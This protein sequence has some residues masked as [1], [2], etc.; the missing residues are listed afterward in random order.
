MNKSGETGSAARSLAPSKMPRKRL[1]SRKT[2]G[3]VGFFS[4]TAAMVMSVHEYPTFAVAGMQIPFFLI[5]AGFLW[6]LPVALC[7]AEMATV[8]S[9]EEEG[10]FSWVGN[11]LGE[12]FGFAATFFQWLQITVCFITTIYFMLSAVAYLFDFPALNDNPLIKLIGVLVVF[13]AASLAQLGG[14]KRTVRFAKFGFL[15]GVVLTTGIL[16]VLGIAYVSS[17]KPLQIDTSASPI[18]DFTQA[19]M[20]VVFVSFLFANMGAEASASHVNEM[21]NPKRDYPLAMLLLVIMATVLNAIGGFT[22]AGVVPLGELSLSG[23]MV[24]AFEAL[25]STLSPGLVWMVK[26]ICALLIIGVIGEI[27]SWIV[28]P[29]RALYAA[30]ERGLLPHELNELN[31]N[32]VPKRIIIVQAI[33]V[34]IWAIVLTLGGG[35][36]NLSYLAALSLTSVIYLVAYLLMFIAYLKLARRPQIKRGYHVPG[37]KIGKFVF[38]IIGF[39]SSLFALIIAFFPPVIIS[40]S[41]APV[42]E[43]ILAGSFIITLV[44]PFIIYDVYGKKHS[45]RMKGPPHLLADEV[46]K[47]IRLQGRGE[48]RMEEDPVKRSS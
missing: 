31:K 28:G 37:G 24:Q 38:A 21:T 27:S 29:S 19:S 40:T 26:I 8:R 10:I 4:I 42:Y 16:F 23:G 6:F 22:V 3:F 32:G 14:I 9:W 12:R 34:T 15:L 30:A 39:L 7:A 18:P 20:L 46:N 33:V 13:W 41:Q 35:G 2:L 25:I 47:F 11:M 44:I 1:G 43:L 45:R 36:S 17:G 48:H 5:A